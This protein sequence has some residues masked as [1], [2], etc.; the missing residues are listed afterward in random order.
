MGLFSG[1]DLTPREGHMRLAEKARQI[2]NRLSRGEIE[3]PDAAMQIVTLAQGY[4]IAGL[5]RGW[6]V[7]PE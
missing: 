6:W 7:T 2:T 5:K 4:A 3:P 1:T